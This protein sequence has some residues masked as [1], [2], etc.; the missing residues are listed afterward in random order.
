VQDSEGNSDSS[1][2]L[3]LGRA[4]EF[5]VETADFSVIRSLSLFSDEIF[6]HPLR[7]TP[8]VTGF[9]GVYQPLGLEIA[10]FEPMDGTYRAIPAAIRDGK[11]GKSGETPSECCI[12]RP[13]RRFDH[14]RLNADP[15][16]FLV[17]PKTHWRD[18]GLIVT[19]LVPRYALQNITETAHYVRCTGRRGG[20]GA[21]TYWRGGKGCTCWGAKILLAVTYIY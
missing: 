10:R 18:Q 20:G 1:E 5:G 6:N 21:Q 17:W 9:D 19:C 4:S 7:C 11:A 12:Y 15:F 13:C 8:F 3:E 16:L 2:S 14:P